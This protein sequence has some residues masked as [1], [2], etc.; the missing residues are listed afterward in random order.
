MDI[1]VDDLSVPYVAD[2]LLDDKKKI[3]NELL[4]LFGLNNVGDKKERLIVD[5]ANAN[6]DYINRNVDLLYKNRK[7]ACDKINEKFGLNISVKR[8]NNVEEK[9]YIEEGELD[10]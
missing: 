7:L 2:K 1:K 5:E 6:N 9:Q 4:T 8:V 3:E 10:G